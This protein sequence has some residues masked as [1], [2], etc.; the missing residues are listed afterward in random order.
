MS[1]QNTPKRGDERAPGAVLRALLDAAI[2]AARPAAA[3]APHL[4]PP[5]RGKLIVLGAGKA[6]GAMAA[7]VEAAFPGPLQGVVAT[8]YGHGAPCGRITVLEAAH[9]TPDEAGRVAARRILA[10]ADAAGPDDLVLCLLSGGGSALLAAPPPGVALA[11]LQAITERLLASGAPIDEINT[12]RKHL[13]EA[14]GGRL[15]LRAAP[16][17]VL[18]L[19]ISDVPGDDPSVIASGPTAADPSTRAEALAILE[20]RGAPLAA[21]VR[22]W[23]ASAAAETPKP[24][25][26]RLAAS[27]IT[28][29]ATPQR[30]LERAAAAARERGYAAH[31]LSDR[32]EGEAREVA[33][34]LGPIARAVAERGAPFAP[35]CVLLSGGETT[36]TLSPARRTGARGGPNAEFALALALA[37][38]GAPRIH[39]LAADTDGVDGAAAVAGAVIGPDSL[40][41]ARRRG[42]DP[43]AALDGH[44]AHG[45]FGALG[46]DVVTGPTLTNVNDFRAI[47]IAAP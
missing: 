10:A 37:L 41:E 27:A 34:A 32:I 8:P 1:G 28:L 13:S 7:A 39:A 46:A 35:P 38:D 36:V 21:P 31:I 9:P 3:L 23:L 45:F 25:D 29:I 14:Q 30:A 26:A 42:L 4:P 16:A 2:E 40:A 33:K 15:A 24:G 47:L 18:T 12:V 6:A 5:P 17:P 11:D 20:R 19:A 22:A 44:D 43:R